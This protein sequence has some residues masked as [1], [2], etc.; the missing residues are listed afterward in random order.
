[1]A[2]Y[3]E[4]NH[5]SGVVSIHQNQAEIYGRSYGQANRSE[6][7]YNTMDT[8]F[9][10]ASGCKLFTAVAISQLVE[11]GLISFDSLLS[12]CLEFSFPLFD[13]GVTVRH[14]LTH[15]SGIP[16]YFDEDVMDDFEELWIDVPMYRIR[17]PKDFL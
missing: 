5:F 9:S 17:S 11:K 3:A 10:I 15:C 7:I 8:R 1:M 14:L 13:P 16:D 6:Q 2:D 12:E 4:S